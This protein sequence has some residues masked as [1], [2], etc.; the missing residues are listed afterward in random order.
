M[1]NASLILACALVT[2]SFAASVK[3]EQHRFYTARGE[4]VAHSRLAPVI[5]HR[6]FPPYLG[7]HV[8]V[9][10]R[11]RPP[12]VVDPDTLEPLELYPR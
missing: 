2:S 6:A 1:K 11:E 3:A 10:M 9:P 7:Q 12:V 4:K 5:V 8:Y